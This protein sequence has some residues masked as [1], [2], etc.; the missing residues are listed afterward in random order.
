MKIELDMY[1]ALVYRDEEGILQRIEMAAEQGRISTEILALAYAVS[2]KISQAKE[3]LVSARKNNENLFALETKMLL[4]I[5]RRKIPEAMALANKILDKY[6]NAAFARYFLASMAIREKKFQVALGHCQTFLQHYPKH[7]NVTLRMSET[8][9]Y[10]KRYQEA[11]QHAKQCK[12]SLEQ[13]LL[14]LL[15]PSVLP[16]YRLMFLLLGVLAAALNLHISVLVVVLF[17]LF[18]GILISLR[19]GRGILIP[20]RLFFLGAMV[21]LSWFLGRWVWWFLQR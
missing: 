7:N 15:I 6:P 11:I 5:S 2:G 3:V 19:K 9:A 13:R 16:R 20:D 10:L 1:E 4:E 18:I 17:T 21:T 8:L 14:V 12:P